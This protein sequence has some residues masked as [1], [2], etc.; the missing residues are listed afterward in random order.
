MR[1]A[2]EQWRLSG[3]VLREAARRPTDWLRGNARGAFR[4]VPNPERLLFAPQDLRTS[5]PTVASDVEAGIFTFA[6]RTVETG[7]APPF[8]V[9]PPSVGWER[10][11]YGFDWLRH[12]RAAETPAVRDQARVLIG[13][14]LKP[15]RRAFRTGTARETRVV[16]RRLISFLCQSPLLLNG[17]D[18]VFYARFLGSVG[19]AVSQ[20]ESDVATARRPL[21]RLAAATALAYA[22]L[23]CSGFENRLKRATRLLCTE[24]D[25]QILPDGGH[26]GRN[27]GVL[28]EL[29]LD[30]LPLRLL[31]KSRSLEVP[32][33]LA[34]AVDRMMPMLRYLRSGPRELAL[35][36]GMGA[37][38]VDQMATLLSYDA[39]RA[40]PPPYA[41]PSGYLRLEAGP[42]EIVADTGAVPPLRSSF[43]ACAGCLSFEF[44]GNGQRLVV[45]TGTPYGIRRSR[46]ASRRT[47][48]HSTLGIGDESSAE[49]LE[50]LRSGF[51]RW[52]VGR[53]GGVVLSGPRDVAVERQEV[54][55]T[56]TATARHDGWA[57]RFGVLHER[58]WRLSADGTRLDGEDRLVATAA[59]N[60]FPPSI[61]RF[62][63]HPAVTATHDGAGAV[64]LAHRDGE[65]W[66][67][68]CEAAAV[69]IEDSVFYGGLEGWRPTRQM[70][71]RLPGAETG[72]RVVAAWSFVRLGAPGRR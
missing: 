27:P 52:L 48:A 36:N 46:E 65:A 9:P 29:L 12:L 5:D 11:L 20:L 2:A 14:A 70:T 19:R 1:W 37:T 33:P 44:S 22:G 38:A 66:R 67:F 39:G 59:G 35:F 62:H 3:L 51:A 17:A 23:C 55:G 64:R 43:A 53:L 61:L 63:L 54:E 16:S 60:R 41:A 8:A 69:R 57:D 31:Y 21:D 40:Q 45:N 24:L 32:E 71:V 47:R 15:G 42:A 49:F 7:G 25:Y 68:A 18:R 34:R 13:A 6:G 10:A 4:R 58:R 50:D 26:V 28:I 56:R 30:L 72:G